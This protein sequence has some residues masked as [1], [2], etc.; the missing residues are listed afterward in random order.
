MGG[1]S[2]DDYL[3]GL[4]PDQQAELTRVNKP[5][6]MALG[7]YLAD[8]QAVA[9]LGAGVSTPLYPLWT[10]LIGDLVDAASG[11][12]SAEEADTCR[13]LAHES[14]EEVVEFVRQQL[15]VAD[16]REV[17]REVLR[18]RTDPETGRSWTPVQELVCRCAFKAVVTTNYDS[19]ILDARIRV[20]PGASSTG[21]TSGPVP[22][23]SR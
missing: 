1:D 9:F 21:F 7:E 15:G 16:Y 19:G 14:P 11:R 13:A 23:P 20:R 10:G 2:A 17:L 8:R 3:Y 22:G 12:L 18:A 6:L 5:G 4:P